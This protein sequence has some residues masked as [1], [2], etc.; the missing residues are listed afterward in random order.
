MYKF[1]Y[2][3]PYGITTS[4]YV[5]S[6]QKKELHNVITYTHPNT[7]TTHTKTHSGI[8]NNRQAYSTSMLY[9]PIRRPQYEKKALPPTKLIGNR[10]NICI[11]YTY[12]I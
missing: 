7:H 9:V 2:T 10:T 8:R 6:V 1:T 5:I 11:R 12:S 3:Q 4:Q